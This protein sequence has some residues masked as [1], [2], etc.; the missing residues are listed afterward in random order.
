MWVGIYQQHKCV[1]GFNWANGTS[2]CLLAKNLLMCL[3]FSL[4]LVWI[5]LLITETSFVNVMET[6]WSLKTSLHVRNWFSNLFLLMLSEWNLLGGPKWL[7]LRFESIPVHFIL[8][9]ILLELL[10]NGLSW[11]IR[12]LTEIIIIFSVPGENDSWLRSP[13]PVNLDDLAAHPSP[14]WAARCNSPSR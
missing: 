10:L 13:V 5:W 14:A 7:H 8:R 12:V 9:R 4:V 1:F 6:M 11:S 3:P 2:F